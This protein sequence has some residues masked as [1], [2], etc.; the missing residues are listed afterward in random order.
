MDSNSEP[1]KGE[2]KGR[3]LKLWLEASERSSLWLWPCLTETLFHTTSS[4][5]KYPIESYSWLN[6]RF[7]AEY[8]SHSPATWSV[9]NSQSLNLFLRFAPPMAWLGFFFF[10]IFPNFS[11]RDRESNSR[12]QSCTSLRDLDSGW[13]TD[14]AVAGWP[15]SIFRKAT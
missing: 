2:K 5:F 3:S 6:P 1:S 14:W 11:C 13:I 15:I 4:F 12:Q 10:T 7:M 8:F 9:F